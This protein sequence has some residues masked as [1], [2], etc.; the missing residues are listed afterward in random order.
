[1]HLISDWRLHCNGRRLQNSTLIVGLY[2]A[3]FPGSCP[4]AANINLFMSVYRCHGWIPQWKPVK[5]RAIIDGNQVS[6]AWPTLIEE[7]ASFIHSL[8][9]Y[10]IAPNLA[11]VLSFLIFS[12]GFRLTL[13]PVPDSWRVVYFGLYWQQTIFVHLG[14][15][16]ESSSKVLLVFQS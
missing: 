5:V 2:H 6:S 15:S 8:N 1:M 12:H 9:M 14:L 4:S 13:M 11:Q 10:Y 16:G 7:N 3:P